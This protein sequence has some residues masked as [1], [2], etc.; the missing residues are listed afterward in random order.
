MNLE[1]IGFIFLSCLAL[2]MILNFFIKPKEP[3]RD[4]AIKASEVRGIP[5]WDRFQEI[6]SEY[7][8]RFTSD[9]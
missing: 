9:E 4:A 8:E 5:G 2:L 1:L 7:Y 6:V 3:A